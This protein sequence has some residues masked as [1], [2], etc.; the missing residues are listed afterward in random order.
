MSSWFTSAIQSVRDKSINALDFVCRDLAEFTTTVKSDTEIYLNQVANQDVGDLGFNRLV[1]KLSD[2]AKTDTDHGKHIHAT[3]SFD[4]IHNELAR[5]QNDESTY[6]SDPI[7]YEAYETW[8]QTTNFNVE[9][10]KGD[11]SRLLIDVPHVRSY[12]ARFVPAQT[13]HVDFWSRYYYRLHLIEE[14][15]TRRT[16][17]LRRAHEICSENNDNP[18]KTDENDWDEPEDAWS[19]EP[20]SVTQESTEKIIPMEKEESNE[21]IVPTEQQESSDEI[22]PMEKQESN[23]ESPAV[24]HQQQLA[25]VKEDLEITPNERKESDTV[26]G[27]S[28]EREFDEADVTSP[29]V[30][31]ASHAETLTESKE[32]TTSESLSSSTVTTT[33]S[34]L[35]SSP[36]NKTPNEFDDDWE[37]WS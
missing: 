8:R 27:D 33:T 24:E 18:G 23:Q 4:R 26:S 11:I 16:Q 37:S 28:W 5:L 7:P 1:S 19:K 12:Y 21:E 35:L 22:V 32:T 10:R 13:T 9:A 17:L 3:P 14:E 36:K 20:S 30:A 34:P 31:I 2:A 15:E 6:L 25:T 29:V